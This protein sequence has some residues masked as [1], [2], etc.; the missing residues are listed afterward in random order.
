VFDILDGQSVSVSPDGDSAIKSSIDVAVDSG[1]GLAALRKLAG[2]GHAFLLNI[3]HKTG[4]DVT[5]RWVFATEITKTNKGTPQQAHGQPGYPYRNFVITYRLVA[6]PEII[7]TPVWTSRIAGDYWA[8]RGATAADMGSY[9]YT[10]VD[11]GADT[12]K[13]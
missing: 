13:L 3:P 10:A 12:R 5:W 1:N 9:Y 6:Q 7:L 2:R 8:S 4:R 11:F